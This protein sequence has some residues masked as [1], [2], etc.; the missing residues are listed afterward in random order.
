MRLCV[1][2]NPTARGNQARRFRARLQTLAGDCAWKPTTAPGAATALAAEA[3]AEGFDTIVAAGGDGTVSEVVTGLAGTSDG[4]A[5]C[6]LAILPLGTINVFARELGLPLKPTAAWQAIQQGH[7]TRVDL[8]VVEFTEAGQPR[9]RWFTQLAGAGLD[10]RAIAQV[11]WQWKQRVGQFAYIAAGLRALRGPQPKI[12]V[13]GGGH[14]AIGELVL[15]GNGRFYGGQIPI[16]PGADLRDGRLDVRVFPRT[17][18]PTLLR[19]GWNWLWRRFPV[20][21]DQVCFRAEQFE[22]RSDMAMPF[23]LDGDNVGLLPARFRVQ[24]QALRVTGVPS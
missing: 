4:L 2:F 9:R 10:S 8:P 6:R 24:P 15:I 1:I 3:V 11:D 22:L 7:E 12:E 20:P 21:A 23:E 16:F 5:R 14:R 17:N 19:F 18:W 13:S